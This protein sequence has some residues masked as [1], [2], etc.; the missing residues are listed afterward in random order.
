MINC[1]ICYIVYIKKK[2]KEEISEED[3]DFSGDVMK[4]HICTISICLFLL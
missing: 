3:S 4:K 2:A 1:N